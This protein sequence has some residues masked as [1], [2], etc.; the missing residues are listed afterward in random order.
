MFDLRVDEI[1]LPASKKNRDNLIS[2][3]IDTLCLH[4]RRGENAADDGTYSPIHRILSE[5]LFLDASRGYETRD[6]AN[7]LGLTT[8]AIHH[9]FSRLV[10]AGL[11]STSSGKGWKTYY[12]VGGSITK[13]IASM[14]VRAN[15]IHS[16]RLEMMDEV[17]NRGKKVAM[18]IELPPDGKPSALIR[19]KEWGPLED[20]E[21]ELS[22]FMADM[23]LLG[24]R[25]GKEIAANSLSVRIF[26]MLLNSGPPISID[27]AAKEL[28]GPKARVGRILE[29]FRATGLVERV[30]RTDRLS[31]ALWSAMTT[32]HMR[33]GEDW[34]LKKGG[35][36][37]L[38]VPNSLL[39]NLKNGNCT[40]NTVE[41]ALKG[42][43][44]REQMLLLNL[45][46]GRLPLGHRLVGMDVSMM[47]Q[48]SI[49][50]LDRI[51]RKIEKV[52]KMLSQ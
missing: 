33:R 39:K 24:E 35:F 28:D 22:R 51:I 37:R 8:A 3:I 40:P 19:I 12:L 36:E 15:L 30:A 4:R 50:N 27:E 5:H 48:K 9:H 2:W 21:S 47:K 31:T 1:P 45:L 49:D 16:Q 42:M 34:L 25:P 38:S 32:Q 26:E 52:G 43:E 23:G 41:K 11:V 46:G 44:A 14:K 18:A 6:L 29:R 13:A 20:G 17:W 7:D 10:S